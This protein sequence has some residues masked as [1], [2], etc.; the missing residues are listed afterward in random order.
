MHVLIGHYTV[1]PARTYG[2]TE[3]VMWWLGKALIRN[4]H[5]V[6]YLVKKGS[7]C[8]FASIINI[9]PS[10]SFSDQIPDDVDLVHLFFQP[11]GKIR[12]P[13]LVTNQGNIPDLK[14]EFP[15]DQNTVFVSRN[16]AQRHHS[17]CFVYNGVDFDDYGAVDINRNRIHYHF[18]AKGSWRAKKPG[19]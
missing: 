11:S 13:Y 4:G 14:K 7:S 10:R 5:N 6:T 16:H 12:T 17:D 18:L 19:R 1:I 3:R 2:G 9:D 8:P 15:L